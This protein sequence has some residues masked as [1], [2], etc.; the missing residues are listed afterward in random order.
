MIVLGKLATPANRCL[1][2][3]AAL[4]LAA[5]LAGCE[6][7]GEVGSAVVS[8]AESVGDWVTDIFDGEEEGEGKPE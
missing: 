7:A 2:G 1:R 6:T 8:G 3:I 5:T 4:L